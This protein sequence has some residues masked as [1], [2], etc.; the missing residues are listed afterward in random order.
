MIDIKL[1][2]ESPKQFYDASKARGFDERYL[3]EF[4]R[5]DKEWRDNLKVINELKH[6]K[7]LQSSLISELI[8]K[9]E[10]PENSKKQVRE[11]NSKID[12][13]E[14]SQKLIEK[15]R[16]RVARLIP[17]LLHESVPVC[18]GDE[19]SVVVRSWGT[20]NVCEDDVNYFK[21]ATA[22]SG[23]F[24]IIPKRPTSHV[25]LMQDLNLVDLERASKTAGSRFYYLK[26]RL[27]KL[28]MAL[29]NYA[30]DF[31]SERGFT[32]VEPPFMLTYK[33]MEGATDMETFKD[34]L[35]KIEGEDLYLISTSEHPIASMYLDETMEEND[36][37]VR[38]AGIS[39]CFRREA[40]AHGKDT[41]GIFRVHQFTKI[42]QFVFCKPEDSW[43][44][45]EELLK[46]AEDIF[47]SLNIPYRVV[48]ICSGDLG[49]LAAKKY[50]IEAWF[51]SQGKF[52]EV[53]SASNDTDYQARS[54]NVKY[55]TKEGNR[56]VHT[57]NSTAIATTR[58]LV[59][60]MENFQTQDESGFK[61]P[62]ALVPYTGFD[63]VSK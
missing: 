2:R 4:F 1:L 32:I 7:N 47:R 17:N 35:Y 12:S 9:H 38:L 60:I 52:R 13:M 24:Q 28:E 18:M 62:E 40:G 42:E 36:L 16:E 31:L 34:T 27:V 41:K 37:P 15:E 23:K 8:K 45:L 21:E 43:D 10:S 6:E 5:L 57:L 51:P 54:L 59:A 14:E 46:N 58:T 61:V 48:N 63:F 50:D 56:F 49:N 11:I 39:P 53:V 55:R 20:S 33:A 19:N 29:V 44:F 22:N 30:V 25:D 3:D 26:N